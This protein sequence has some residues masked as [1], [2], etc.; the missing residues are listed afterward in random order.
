MVQTLTDLSVKTSTLKVVL[1]DVQTTKTRL[2][3][4][5]KK[6]PLSRK[7]TGPQRTCKNGI[8]ETIIESSLPIF[9]GLLGDGGSLSTST[10]TSV[11]LDRERPPHGGG[12]AP[13]FCL[14]RLGGGRQRRRLRE[15]EVRES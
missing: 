4:N 7:T 14:G 1:T 5:E 8:I 13:D 3:S 15:V 2:L 6:E 11:S 12:P 9:F 10:S